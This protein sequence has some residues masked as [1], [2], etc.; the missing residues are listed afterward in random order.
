MS[1]GVLIADDHRIIREGIRSLIEKEADMKFLAA[2][3]DGRTVVRLARELAPDVIIMDISMPDMNGVSTTIAILSEFPKMKVIALSVLKDRRIVLNML[4][5]GAMGYLVK[6]CSFKELSR[7]IRLVMA[8]RTYLSSAV[9]DILV[10][11]V[12]RSPNWGSAVY[13]RLS[14]R[15]TEILQL[16]SEGKSTH[17]IADALNVSSKT[18]ETHRK[19]VMGKLNIN[20]IPGLTKYAVREGLTSA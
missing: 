6:D 7:A 16:I 20:N 2:A 13:A 19:H 1:I 5:A 17:Q 3:E 4:K 10:E 12:S 8:N 15:E 9:T 11:E 14:F 18:I